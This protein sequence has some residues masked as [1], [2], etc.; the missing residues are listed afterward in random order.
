M[1]VRVKFVGGVSGK[2][3]P[4]P[5]TSPLTPLTAT[6]SGVRSALLKGCPEMGVGVLFD[7]G[8]RNEPLLVTGLW[9]CITTHSPLN[10]VIERK[11]SCQIWV[12]CFAS[13]HTE[14]LLR[15]KR[16]CQVLRLIVRRMF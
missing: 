14:T 5:D 7:L 10:S 4:F 15:A 3:M 13:A 16:L 12:G 6:T 1:A 9:H 2:L 11:E 8:G